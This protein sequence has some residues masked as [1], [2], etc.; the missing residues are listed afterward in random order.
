MVVEGQPQEELS[1]GTIDTTPPAGSSVLPHDLQPVFTE[2]SKPWR[3]E[4]KILCNS[5]E[6]SQHSAKF[7][8][9]V[10]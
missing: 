8:L 9:R 4:V 6:N 10:H 3:R 7:N 1:I 2:S 5:F